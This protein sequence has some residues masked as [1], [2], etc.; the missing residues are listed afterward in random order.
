[1]PAPKPHAESDPDFV[2]V[3]YIAA[4]PEKVWAALVD[5]KTERAWWWNTRH[6]SDFKPGSSIR[7]V[8]NGEVDIEG[9]VLESDPPNRLVYTFRSGSPG[10]QHDEGYTQVEHRIEVY[11]GWTKLT[12]IHSNFKRDSAVRKGVSGGWPAIL[13]G[14]KSVLEGVEHMPFARQG[15]V[16]K[17]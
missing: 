12:L 4:P 14:L 1:M 16:S 11:D 3:V 5:N 9:E 8:R 15:E 6:D 7:Y 17:A 13:S 2:Y 10:P